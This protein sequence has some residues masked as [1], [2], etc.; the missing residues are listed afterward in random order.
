MKTYIKS[1]NG[2]GLFLGTFLSHVFFEADKEETPDLNEA[3]PYD[4]SSFQAAM[5]CL[6]SWATNLNDY[7]IITL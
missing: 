7:E 3:G 5:D 1:K 4:F 2:R 6:K